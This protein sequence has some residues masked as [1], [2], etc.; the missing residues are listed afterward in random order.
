MALYGHDVRL[1]GLH[2][3]QDLVGGGETLLQG[4]VDLQTSQVQ[5]EW[6]HLDISLSPVGH[7]G[8]DCQQVLTDLQHHIYLQY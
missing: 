5:V 6:R 2:Q 7:A 3:Q 4:G 1:E 8:C